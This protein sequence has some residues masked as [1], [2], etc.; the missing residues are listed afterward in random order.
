MFIAGDNDIHGKY[1]C[2]AWNMYGEAMA[3]TEVSGKAAPANFKSQY[4]SK[5][6]TEYTLEWVVSEIFFETTRKIILDSFSKI[7]LD[8]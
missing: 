4:M 5:D 1:D 7:V 8:A 2:R 3:T 6:E